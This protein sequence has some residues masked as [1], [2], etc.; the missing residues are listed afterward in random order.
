MRATDP[1]SV[2]TPMTVSIIMLHSVA[3]KRWFFLKTQSSVKKCS[4]YI[5]QNIYFR[6]FNNLNYVL[7]NLNRIAEDEL[8]NEKQITK[9]NFQTP[10]HQRRLPK[11]LCFIYV[12][13][14][15]VFNTKLYLLQAVLANLRPPDPD[16]VKKK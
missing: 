6:K 5:E 2:I 11:Y 12:V 15:N 8:L 3:E 10:S 16:K 9:L 1:Y 14:Y 13:T 4:K 7:E